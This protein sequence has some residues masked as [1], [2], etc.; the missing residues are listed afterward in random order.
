MYRYFKIDNNTSLEEVKRQYRNL[1]VQAHPDR[2]GGSVEK[3]RAVNE[4]YRKA[5]EEIQSRAEKI[6]DR[7][8][9][10]LINEQLV[11][12][13]SLIDRLKVPEQFKPAISYL[14]ELGVNK[15][16]EAIQQKLQK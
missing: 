15:L 12:I 5:L 1:A 9:Y 11:N 13:D 3:F 14:V 10:K 4:E 6:G 16:E 7:R 8:L 2:D